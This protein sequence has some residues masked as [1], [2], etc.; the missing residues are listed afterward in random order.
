MLILRG[1]G[2]GVLFVHH[3]NKMNQQRGSSMR[4]VQTEM[5][6]RLTSTKNGFRIDTT[7]QRSNQQ[8][9]LD[10]RFMDCPDD[11]IVLSY[12]EASI[13]DEVSEMAEVNMGAAAI[14]RAL[15]AD[16]LSVRRIMRDG[17]FK[18]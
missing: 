7:K 14:S 12:G 1:K 4:E 10:V 15:D 8:M 3:A 5:N 9:F 17:G 13:K 11:E 6:V 2:V 18:I 16:E